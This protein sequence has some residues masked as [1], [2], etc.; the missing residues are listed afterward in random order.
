MTA[1]TYKAN[2]I[3]VVRLHLHPVEIGRN[4]SPKKNPTSTGPKRYMKGIEITNNRLNK[5]FV[6]IDHQ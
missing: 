6:K 3:S 4:R 1:T 5:I 2:K